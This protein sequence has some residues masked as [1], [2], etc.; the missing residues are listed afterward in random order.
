VVGQEAAAV[1]LREHAG[2]A[3]PLARRVAELLRRLAGAE[4]EDVHDEQVARLGALHLDRAAEHV[5]DRQ[6]DITDVVRG[7]VVAELGVRPLAAFDAELAARRHRCRRWNVR[8]PAVVAGY[9]LVGHRLGLVDAE[10]DLG[11][12][13][14]PPVG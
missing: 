6:V 10:D 2:V 3:P 13:R 9:G 12:G 5:A 4:V 1:D 8:V 14:P 11:H 7:V